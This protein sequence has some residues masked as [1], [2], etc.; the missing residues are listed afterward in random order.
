VAGASIDLRSGETVP[1]NG[2][3]DE[4]DNIENG[5]CSENER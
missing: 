4:G 1:D 5:G 3:E 2:D